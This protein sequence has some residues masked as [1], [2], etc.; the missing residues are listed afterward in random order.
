MLFFFNKNKKG[1][2][3]F[4]FYERIGGKTREVEKKRSG[5]KGDFSVRINRAPNFKKRNCTL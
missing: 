1:D 3:Y 2:M 5:L 4:C